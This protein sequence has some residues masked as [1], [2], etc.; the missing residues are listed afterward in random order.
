MPHQFVQLFECALVQQ[1]VDAF[2]RR[3]LPLPVLTRFA[4]RTTPFLCPRV[5]LA[6]LTEP[7][8][9][10]YLSSVPPGSHNSHRGQQSLLRRIYVWPRRSAL[11]GSY[12][13]YPEQRLPACD[14]S[15]NSCFEDGSA[16]LPTGLAVSTPP[17]LPHPLPQQ[18]ETRHQRRN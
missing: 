11:R 15:A 13:R 4:L 16:S 3:Q 14:R 10:H 9:A 8:G 7:I 1:E 5:P 12:G 17:R 2:A 18:A 6:K